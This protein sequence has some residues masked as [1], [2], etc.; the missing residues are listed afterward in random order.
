MYDIWIYATTKMIAEMPIMLIVPG[1]FLLL[2]Y[3]AIGLENDAVQFLL[4]YVI[5]MLV[6]QAATAMG[7]ALSSAFNEANTAVAFAPIINMPLN[8]LAGYMINLNNIFSKSPQRYVAWFQYLSPVRY[9]YFAMCL[10]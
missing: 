5:I 10:L 3:F 9:G 4:Y 6:M 7:Y 8:L 2:V 1:I